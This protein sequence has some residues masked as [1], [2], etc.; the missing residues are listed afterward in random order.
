MLLPCSTGYI[1]H[2]PHAVFLQQRHHP[3]LVLLRPALCVSD[4][5]LPDF[6][7]FPVGILI[8]KPLRSHTKRAGPEYAVDRHAAAGTCRGC[9]AACWAC[10]TYS[11]H[12]HMSTVVIY[13]TTRKVKNFHPMTRY[14]MMTPS[15][16]LAEEGRNFRVYVNGVVLR[17]RQETSLCYRYFHLGS[18]KELPG[19]DLVLK[20]PC[21]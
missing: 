17:E 9:A 10:V 13:R 7:C 18:F 16:W 20:A 1:Q 19:T 12:V 2:S 14:F 15:F 5:Q 8:R 6:S 4:V 3:A 11:P 21:R